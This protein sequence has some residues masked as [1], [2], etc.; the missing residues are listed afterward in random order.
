LLFVFCLFF[1]CF[2]NGCLLFVYLLFV[3]LFILLFIT[4]I[5]VVHPS[6]RERGTILLRHCEPIGEAIQESAFLDCFGLRPRNDGT[7]LYHSVASWR[8]EQPCRSRPILLRHC[9][10]IGEAIQEVAFWF[11]SGFALAMTIL[12]PFLIFNS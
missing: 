2:L 6:L 12:H 8:A 4:P 5:S 9:E 10:P 7:L 3:L 1:V 11:A